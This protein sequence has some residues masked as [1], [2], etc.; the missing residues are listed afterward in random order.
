MGTLTH[1]KCQ[2]LLKG[3]RFYAVLKIFAINPKTFDL[4]PQCHGR[5]GDGIKIMTVLEYI[6]IFEVVNCIS[7]YARL[8][9]LID[10]G[11]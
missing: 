7:R 9:W 5:A 6:E 1:M 3:D 8:L 11:M 2:I 4:I 10:L